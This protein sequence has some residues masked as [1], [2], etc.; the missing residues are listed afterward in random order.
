MVSFND[1]VDIYDEDE[2]R[3]M[4]SEIEQAVIKVWEHEAAANIIVKVDDNA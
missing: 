1:D 3:A 2:L 4:L